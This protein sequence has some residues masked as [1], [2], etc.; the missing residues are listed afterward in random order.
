MDRKGMPC[1]HIL[2]VLT[3]LKLS[4]IPKCLVLRRL[5]KQASYGLPARRTSDLF[6]WGWSGIE[7]RNK[8]SH[9]SVLGAEAFHVVCNDPLLYDEMEEYL[10]NTIA[11]KRGYDTR[12]DAH[13]KITNEAA[14]KCEEKTVKIG[15]PIKVSTKGARKQST[16][17]PAKENPPSTRNGRPLGFNERKR[18]QVCGVCKAS[19]HNRRSS[20][21]PLHPRYFS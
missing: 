20:K 1:K 14:Q 18:Q 16:Q 21:C 7:E 11:K 10:R 6:G 9:L 12:A 3:R 15:D 8:F 13:R 5:S 17:V 19:G 2:Y 4:D